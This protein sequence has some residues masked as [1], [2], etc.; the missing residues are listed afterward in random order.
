MALNIK[1]CTPVC[2]HMFFPRKLQIS[3][4]LKVGGHRKSLV[5][6]VALSISTEGLL[7]ICDL[8]V[9][10]KGLGSLMT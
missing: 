5:L 7:N 1:Q 3:C 9:H 6:T 4:I 2:C 8:S 10:P